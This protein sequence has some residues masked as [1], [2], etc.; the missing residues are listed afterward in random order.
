MTKLLYSIITVVLMLVGCS[1][2]SSTSEKQETKGNVNKEEISYKDKQGEIVDFINNDIQKIIAYE[3]EANQQLA[4]VSGDN[5]NSDKELYEVLTSKVIPT[6]E[7]AV[8]EARDLQV[9][10]EEL[11]PMKLKIKEATSTY[12]EALIL[13]KKALEKKDKGLIEESNKKGQEYIELINSYH[14]EMKKLASKY[15]IDYQKN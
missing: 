8:N 2:D 4:T 1:N 10:T 13:E 14:E 15:E 3:T 9:S 5:Y 12:Y 11:E 7:K 6:Y